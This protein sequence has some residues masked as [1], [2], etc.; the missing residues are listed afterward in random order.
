MKK[1]DSGVASSCQM[2]CL[3]SS[4]LPEL[5]FN[6]KSL[7]TCNPKLHTYLWWPLS[8]VKMAGWLVLSF[9][10]QSWSY[11]DFCLCLYLWVSLCVCMVDSVCVCVLVLGPIFAWGDLWMWTQCVGLLVCVSWYQRWCVCVCDGV[12]VC[13][14]TSVFVYVC[15]CLYKCVLVCIRS[16]P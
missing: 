7:E 8:L 11:L 9:R 13:L 2:N 15:V 5:A 16:G 3:R 6:F 14:Y 12:C 10:G 1:F 4:Q